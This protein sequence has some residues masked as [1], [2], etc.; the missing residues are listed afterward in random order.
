MIPA[1]ELDTA[2][3]RYET[4][5]ASVREA[6][7]H[8]ALVKKSALLFFCMSMIAMLYTNRLFLQD[9]RSSMR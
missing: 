6:S 4:A 5:K 8:L 2:R 9:A 7:E 1:R 3:M